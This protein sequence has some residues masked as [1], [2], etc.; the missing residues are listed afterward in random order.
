MITPQCTAAVKVWRAKAPERRSNLRAHLK[1]RY[2]LALEDFEAM[3]DL[4]DGKCAICRQPEIVKGRL[5]VDHNHR[6]TTV[7]WA[8]IRAGWSERPRI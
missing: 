1:Y 2:G 3:H 7:S 8:M 5:S 6:T 4:Q